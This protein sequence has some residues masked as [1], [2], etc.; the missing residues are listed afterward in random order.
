MLCCGSAD[1][2]LVKKDYD[3]FRF[4][5]ILRYGFHVFK[6]L[7]GN[8]YPF[9]KVNGQNARFVGRGALTHTFI[10]VTDIDCKCGDRVEINISPLYVADKVKR[11]YID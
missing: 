9:A 5:D 7:F 2:V 8:N 6:M 3:T 10:D 4:I 11:E 1:G